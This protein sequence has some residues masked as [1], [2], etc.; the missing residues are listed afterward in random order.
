MNPEKILAVRTLKTIYKDRQ[1][2]M[3][4]FHSGYK[5]ADVLNEALNQARIEDTDIAIP[6]IISVAKLDEKWVITS[7]F[8]KGKTLSQLMQEN[9][10]EMEKYLEAFVDTQIHM[11]DQEPPLLNK[12]NDKLDREIEKSE[13]NATT[14]YELRMRLETLPGPSCICHGDFNPSNIIVT[15]KNEYYILDWSHVSTGNKLADVARTYLLLWNDFEAEIAKKYIDSYC[16]KANVSFEEI[17]QWLPIVA[18]SQSTKGNPK[19][20][21]FLL[22]WLKQ[23]DQNRRS[24]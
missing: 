17:N 9:P 20:K 7:E 8:I 10:E 15:D 3:K 19:E 14:R 11:H 21:E 2:V 23:E 16:M 22:S 24:V 13:L 1:T 5:K 12:L 6:K 4:V 18:A